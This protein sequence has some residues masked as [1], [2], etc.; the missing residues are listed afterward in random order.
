MIMV[1]SFGKKIAGCH[2]PKTGVNA[3]VEIF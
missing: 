3:T 1:D 2:P